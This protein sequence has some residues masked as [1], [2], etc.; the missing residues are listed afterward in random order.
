MTKETE[1]LD[2]KVNDNSSSSLKGKG[3]VK[4]KNNNQFSSAEKSLIVLMMSLVKQNDGEIRADVQM[5]SLI[6]PP[7][8][9]QKEKEKQIHSSGK[10]DL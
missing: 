1:E 5:A 7:P 10:R 9:F 2:G 4:K 8:N 6:L 3:E